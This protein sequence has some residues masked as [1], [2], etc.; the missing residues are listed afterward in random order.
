M[1]LFERLQGNIQWAFNLLRK[2][3]RRRQQQLTCSVTDVWCKLQDSQPS[4]LL[5]HSF[6][7]QDVEELQP[8]NIFNKYVTTATNSADIYSYPSRQLTILHLKEGLK[9]VIL[10]SIKCMKEF[11]RVVLFTEIL[12]GWFVLTV[13][14]DFAKQP[15]PRGPLSHMTTFHSTGR[16]CIAKWTWWKR[17]CTE[18][19]RR[20]LENVLLDAK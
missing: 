6:P 12:K 11:T 3:S 4:G 9:H 17:T 19:K 10:N 14:K 20:Q 5:F 13:N 2:R 1:K 7:F 18:S 15:Q 16:V 8:E